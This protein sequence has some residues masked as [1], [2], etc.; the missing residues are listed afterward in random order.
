MAPRLKTIGR[1]IER[2]VKDERTGFIRSAAQMDEARA[3]VDRIGTEAME[4]AD[5]RENEH[6][7]EIQDSVTA[8]CR[9]AETNGV[10]RA[11]KWTQVPSAWRPEAVDIRIDG[12][13]A[14]TS[15]PDELVEQ[16]RGKWAQLWAP[17]AA[18]Q[19]LPEWGTVPRL[20][21]PTAREVRAAARRF[22][23]DT[24]QGA[25]QLSSRDIG[26]LDDTSLEL[27]IEIMICS[28]L[29]GT[30]PEALALVIVALPEK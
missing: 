6:R 21:R 18:A 3:T 19:S 30:V 14:T 7:R 1:G 27:D 12:I 13:V 17:Q 28:E 24:G 15:N 20:P 11:H 9:E 29:I 25:D 10:G 16:E 5:A 22:R 26:E 23:R 8:W 2:A 4:T